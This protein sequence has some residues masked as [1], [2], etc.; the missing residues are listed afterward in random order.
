[1]RLPSPDGDNCRRNLESDGVVQRRKETCLDADHR[2]KGVP[3][4]KYCMVKKLAGAEHE[5]GSVRRDGTKRYASRTELRQSGQEMKN[6]RRR[7]KEANSKGQERDFVTF[8]LDHVKHSTVRRQSK[9]E[10][11]KRNQTKNS[12]KKLAR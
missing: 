10:G 9:E 1:M 4:A 2:K 7:R 12:Q 11:I 6:G 5:A 8:A 3:R